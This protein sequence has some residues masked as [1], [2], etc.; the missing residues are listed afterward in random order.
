MEEKKTLYERLGGDPAIQG[1]VDKM[2]EGIFTDAELDDF[3]RKTDKEHQKKQQHD[4]LTTVT[5]GPDIYKGKN[6]LDA[7]K[8][9]GI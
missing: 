1:V 6:M 9:R 8:G 3:F 7:H 2:Y 5:G 4:F